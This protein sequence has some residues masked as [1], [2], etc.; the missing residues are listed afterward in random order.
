MDEILDRNHGDQ[1]T[2]SSRRGYPLD[3]DA[4]DEAVVRACAENRTVDLDPLEGVGHRN[5][6]G[7]ARNPSNIHLD[8]EAAWD[9]VD[10]SR[11]DVPIPIPCG[12]HGNPETVSHAH[13]RPQS[14][15][16]AETRV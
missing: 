8:E 11:H 13:F 15:E 3:V 4:L 2:V 1:E 10:P 5:R 14:L 6:M 9:V 7:G 16:I 12:C